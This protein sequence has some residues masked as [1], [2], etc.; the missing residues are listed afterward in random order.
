MIRMDF[1]SFV[2]SIIVSGV[3]HFLFWKGGDNIRLSEVY[4]DWGK[5]LV[6]RQFV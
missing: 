4:P 5:N 6:S 3:L 1:I 2:I